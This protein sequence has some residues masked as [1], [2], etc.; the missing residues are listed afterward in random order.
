MQ[1]QWKAR[2]TYRGKSYECTF[3]SLPIRLIARI[4]F[5]LLCNQYHAPI[6]ADY[7]LEEAEPS[8]FVEEKGGIYV[9]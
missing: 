6:P 1:I 3:S 8:T 4:D 2:W 5:Q 9:R 7:T